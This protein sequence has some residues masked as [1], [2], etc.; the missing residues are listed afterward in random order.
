[1]KIFVDTNVWLSGRFRPGLCA[2]LLEALVEMDAVILLDERVFGEFRRIARDK[3][4]VDGDTVARAELF[5]RQYA[6]VVPAAG[7]P[8]AGI[9]DSDDAWI[10]AAALSAG[11]DWFVTGDKALL[12]LGEIEGLPVIAPREAYTRLRGIC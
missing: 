3:L 2:E 4:K 7:Q 9:P 8:A 6:V 12:A 11:A 10:I 5:F 1:M